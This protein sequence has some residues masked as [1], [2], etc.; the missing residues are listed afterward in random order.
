MFPIMN[1]TSVADGI[2]EKIHAVYKAAD[3]FD[4]GV[5]RHGEKMESDSF[6]KRNRKNDQGLSEKMRGIF[7]SSD[8]AHEIPGKW[9]LPEWEAY[10]GDGSF[11]VRRQA[12][13][14]GR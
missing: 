13:A 3:D 6:R 1:R 8:Q 10:Q 4:T 5:M 12:G 2:T 7:R 11:K 14:A 9:N